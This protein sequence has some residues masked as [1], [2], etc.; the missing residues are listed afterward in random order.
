MP[1]TKPDPVPAPVEVRSVAQL[2]TTAQVA[3]RL[4]LDAKTVRRIIDRRELP[5]YRVGREF[6]VH[7]DHLAKY[8]EGLAI[9]PQPTLDGAALA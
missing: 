3:D 7:P 2:L 6:R 5:A 4:Q 9:H 8:L 1:R